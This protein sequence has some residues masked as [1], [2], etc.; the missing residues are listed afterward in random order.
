MDDVRIPGIAGGLRRDSYNRYTL[1]AAQGM[2]P[3]G[4]MLHLIDD[5]TRQHIRDLPVYQSEERTILPPG[6]PLYDR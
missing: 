6:S 4:A 3:E 2:M 5:S 1:K